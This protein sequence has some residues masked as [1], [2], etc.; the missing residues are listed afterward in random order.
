MTDIW[1]VEEPHM[2]ERDQVCPQLYHN[3]NPKPFTRMW[4]NDEYVVLKV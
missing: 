4:S 3:K 1:D 2:I